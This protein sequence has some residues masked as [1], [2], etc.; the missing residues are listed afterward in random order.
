MVDA[1]QWD[2][3][4]AIF[5]FIVAW[6]KKIKVTVI[7]YDRSIMIETLEENMTALLGDYIIKGVKGEIYQCK[8]DIFDLI[9]EA[10]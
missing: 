9:Y 10:C 3:S 7:S 5:D 2:G 1:I 8:P 6:N 4:A